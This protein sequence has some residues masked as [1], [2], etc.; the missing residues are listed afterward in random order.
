MA[1]FFDPRRVMLMTDVDGRAVPDGPCASAASVTM[2]G[3]RR[4]DLASGGPSG[5]AAMRETCAKPA[6][7]A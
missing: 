7:R 4:R 5:H 6:R 1:M 2:I 3:L